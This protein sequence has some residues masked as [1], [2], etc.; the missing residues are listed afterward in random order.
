MIKNS[1]EGR[2]FSGFDV[3]TVLDAVLFSGQPDVAA[4]LAEQVEPR[5]TLI[6]D[7]G[8]EVETPSGQTITLGRHEWTKAEILELDINDTWL[9]IKAISQVEKGEVDIP[10]KGA[11]DEASYLM[12]QWRSF[13]FAEC[14]IGYPRSRNFN[15]GHKF[16][17]NQS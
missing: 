14:R 16:R 5:K 1:L 3:R 9:A 10:R 4:R 7:E 13:P 17:Q 2:T 8:F 12:Q 15:V 11:R 6:M